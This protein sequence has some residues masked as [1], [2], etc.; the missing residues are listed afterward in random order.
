MDCKPLFNPT[1]KQNVGFVCGNFRSRAK[2]QF[3][4][5]RVEYECDFPVG[6]K[7]CD[8]KICHSCAKHFPLLDSISD[9]LAFRDSKDFCPTHKDFVFQA[10]AHFIFVVN[11]DFSLEPNAQL[12]DRN[13]PLGT[14]YRLTKDEP[15]LRQ[16]CLRKYKR[17]LWE[18]IKLPSSAPAQEL[19]RLATLA[20]EED[21]YLRCWCAPKPCHGQIVAAAICY[22]LKGQNSNG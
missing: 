9:K 2:C 21:V 6:K 1:T 5:N 12:I 8:K 4:G 15:Y 11:S 16:E 14:P 19:R 3:C 20:A 13:T 22:L 18:N 10:G 7:T 17:W